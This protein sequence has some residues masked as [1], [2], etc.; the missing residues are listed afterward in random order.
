MAEELTL[1]RQPVEDHTA[2]LIV[3]GELE[4][5]NCATVREAV[6]ELLA[7]SVTNLVLDLTGLS[8]IDSSG[9]GV[10]IG[11]LKRV[12]ERNGALTLVIASPAIHRVFEIT[13]LT[14][15]F[16]IFPT[17]DEALAGLGKGGP[18]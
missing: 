15:V 2:V 11:A 17:R 7:Q 14:E 16:A 18:L 13:G 5:A 10:V 6:V 12:R 9:V 3:R 8:F 4:L 1:E